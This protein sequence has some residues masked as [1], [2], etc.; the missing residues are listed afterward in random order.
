MAAAT[1]DGNS[2]PAMYEAAGAAVAQARSGGG[3]TFLECLT[4]RLGG[5]TFGAATDYMDPDELA[6]AEADEPVAA[7]PAVAR[8]RNEA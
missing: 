5:H 8:A 1:V 4:Y 3:P 7:H 2:V 6:K